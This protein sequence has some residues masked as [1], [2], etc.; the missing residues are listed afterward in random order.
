MVGDGKSIETAQGS[1][2]VCAFVHHHHPRCINRNIPTNY[3]F[4][5]TLLPGQEQSECIIGRV[6]YK[7]I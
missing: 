3:T 1:M 2:N 4:A 7:T 6:R 5:C